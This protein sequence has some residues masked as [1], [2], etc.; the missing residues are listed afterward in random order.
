MQ[1]QGVTVSVSDLARSKAFYEEVLGFV[2]D[3]YYAPT[4]WQPYKFE[5]RAYFAIIEVADL[6][7]AP[8]ADVVNF[9]VHD[10][11]SLWDRVRDRAEVE[12]E[13]GETPW[14]S[15]RFIVRDPDGW[16]LGFAGQ[17]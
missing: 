6:Q 9:D 7:R 1:V 17:K 13:L 15:Y 10:V 16:R 11:A 8:W 5:G 14:G 4:R 12:A 2:P 3:A